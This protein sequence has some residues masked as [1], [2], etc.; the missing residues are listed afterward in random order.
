MKKLRV[1]NGH[2]LTQLATYLGIDSGALSKI[3]NSKKKLDEKVL[4]K[5]AETFNLDFEILKNEFIS[6]QI[7]N[8]IYESNC[9][10]EV[11]QLAEKKVNYIKQRNAKQIN[12]TF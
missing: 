4:P 7:A 3:E 5:I 12:L 9:S 11:L 1:E 8:K 10:K 6:E 2:T